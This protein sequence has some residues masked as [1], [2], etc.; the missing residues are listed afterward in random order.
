ML[1]E[2]LRGHYIL[3]NLLKLCQQGRRYARADKVFLCQNLTHP[4]GAPKDDSEAALNE[5]HYS[6]HKAAQKRQVA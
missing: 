6:D 2:N 5:P 1:F 3:G 4:F